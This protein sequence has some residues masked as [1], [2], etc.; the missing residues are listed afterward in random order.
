MEIVEI[1]SGINYWLVRAEGGKYFDDFLQN[2]FISISNNEINLE[3]LENVPENMEVNFYYKQ[4]FEEAY[5]NEEMNAQRIAHAVSRID[6]FLNGIKTGDI[7]MVPSH[8]STDFLIGYVESAVYEINEEKLKEYNTEHFANNPYYKRRKVRWIKTVKRHEIS[9][10]LY[11]ILS[12]HQ[13][14]LNLTEQKDYMN[15]LIAPIYVQ[16]GVYHS[17]LR[18]S[19]EDGLTSSEW[20]QLYKIIELSKVEEDDNFIVKSNV[21]SP[22]W[23]EFVSTNRENIVLVSTILVSVTAS[24]FGEIKIKNSTVKGLFPYLRDRE[25]HKKEMELKDNEIEK[26]QIELIM[27]KTQLPTLEAAEKT[28]QLEEQLKQ[29][30]LLREISSFNAG[31]NVNPPETQT[32]NADDQD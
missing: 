15:Q 24:L 1:E 16:D 21:Q 12:A 23:L 29:A 18:V 19:K 17:T 5:K 8:K 4:L 25:N 10:K 28:K 2:S 30:H 9:E 11:W 31:T 27:Q 26:G 3:T 22:G 7:V 32:D 20:Y 13:T 6:K 14:I